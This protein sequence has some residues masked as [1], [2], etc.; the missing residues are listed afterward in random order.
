MG[1]PDTICL[2]KRPLCA[3]AL[4]VL[5]WASLARGETKAVANLSAHGGQKALSAAFSSRETL[6]AAA[7]A[8]APCALEGGTS[9]SV[10]VEVAANVPQAKLQPLRIGLGR[11]VLLVTVPDPARRRNW[12]TLIAGPLSGDKPVVLFAGWTGFVQGLEGERS[13]PAIWHEGSAVYVGE[14][15]ENRDLCGRPALLAPEAVDPRT[16]TLRPAKLMRLTAAERRRAPRLVATHAVAAESN[17]PPPADSGASHPASGVPPAAG[18]LPA[19]GPG[20]TV[21]RQPL[22]SSVWATSA[23]DGF[24]PPA[25][26]D[27]DVG[28]AWREGRGGAGRGEFVVLRTASELPVEGFEFVPVQSDATADATAPR[29]FWIATDTALFAVSVPDGPE[30][31]AGTRYR[32]RL[33]QR[34]SVR[35]VAIVLDAATRDDPDSAVGLAEFDAVTGFVRSQLP[36]LVEKLAAGGAE[37][38]AAAA[39][40]RGGGSEATRAVAEAFAALGENGRRLAL[41][42]LDGGS[43]RVAMPAYVMALTG[44]SGAQAQHARRRIRACGADAV[45]ALVAGLSAATGE[46]R[47]LIADEL[48]RGAPAEAVPVFVRA[49][50]TAD[51]DRRRAIRSALAVASRSSRATAAVNDALSDSHLTEVQRVDLLRAIAPRVRHFNAAPAAFRSLV[52]PGASF[53]TRFLLLG[54][55]GQLA[56]VDPTAR[57][58]LTRSLSGDTSPHI[59]AQAARSVVDPQA[60]RSELLRALSDDAVRVREAA[61]IRLGEAR[62]S[63]AG[64]ALT[65]RLEDDPWPF[66]RVAAARAIGHLPSA[67]QLDGALIASLDDDPSVAVRTAVAL[68]LGRRDVRSAAEVL[69]DRLEDGDED[70]SVRAAAAA[71]AGMICDQGAIDLLTEHARRLVDPHATADA[72]IIGRS[73]IGALGRIHPPD[74]QQRLAPLRDRRVPAV[75]RDVASAALHAQSTCAKRNRS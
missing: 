62:A 66:V 53:R 38:E 35:C 24:W 36:A 33:D 58:F 52:G 13:G 30:A 45:P 47:A 25:L 16:L 73:A 69:R 74:L 8:R 71:A 19:P 4:L 63:Y 61:A 48:A 46:G 20:A 65:V 9:I 42:V 54:V 51:A 44:E 10:P 57:E 14:R 17:T 70:A 55:A 21:P 26:V 34:V 3:I 1:S 39:V 32:V 68:A 6:Q 11:K 59:R 22:L 67:V 29:E 15:K 75:F 5:G 12:E 56:A 18:A 31:P 72:R 37:A 28:T 27:G 23:A 41:D 7:C 43:C 60:L 64:T 2:V 49:L 40:L 50:D